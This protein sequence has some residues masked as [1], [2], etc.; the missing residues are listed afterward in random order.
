MPRVKFIQT[1][2]STQTNIPASLKVSFIQSFLNRLKNK[3]SLVELLSSGLGYVISS[4]DLEDSLNMLNR[5]LFN[6]CERE[7][8]IR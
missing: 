1:F 2:Q 5:E 7:L 6:F 4:L 8:E 3:A